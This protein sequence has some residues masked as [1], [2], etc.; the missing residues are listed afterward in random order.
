MTLKANVSNVER[1]VLD[2][3][4]SISGESIDE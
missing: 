1:K 4:M 2:F 3:K